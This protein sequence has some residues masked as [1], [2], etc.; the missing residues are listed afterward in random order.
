M[1]LTFQPV[2]VN[3]ILQGIGQLPCANPEAAVHCRLL[4][5]T[6]IAEERFQ[7]ARREVLSKTAA[8]FQ[9]MGQ[10]LFQD[11]KHIC[12]RFRAEGSSHFPE[13]SGS[14]IPIPAGRKPAASFQG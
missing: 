1:G 3:G 6:L 7:I 4:L 11:H 5:L 10:L 2:I 13:A 14:D 12:H 9:S 8:S